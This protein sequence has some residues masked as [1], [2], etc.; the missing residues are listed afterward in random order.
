MLGHLALILGVLWAHFKGERLFLASFVG[1]PLFGG[2]VLALFFH[3][4]LHQVSRIG[5]S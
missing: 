5:V 1:S 2:Y 4:E 3:W